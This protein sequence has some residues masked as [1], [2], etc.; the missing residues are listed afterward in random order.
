MF[1]PLLVI[2]TNLNGFMWILTS[3]STISNL[4]SISTFLILHLLVTILENPEL[5]T[6]QN[7]PSFSVSLALMPTSLPLLPLT[8]SCHNFAFFINANSST[9]PSLHPHLLFLITCLCLVLLTLFEYLLYANFRKAYSWVRLEFLLLLKLI[10]SICWLCD[11]WLIYSDTFYELTSL[12]ITDVWRKLL[13][14]IHKRKKK[15]TKGR[16]RQTHRQIDR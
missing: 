11:I 8:S 5:I 10:E 4:S 1:F 2:L 14:Q 6:L 3:C 16:K 15:E 7:S 13:L 12:T 9:F